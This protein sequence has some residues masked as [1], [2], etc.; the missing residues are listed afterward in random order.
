MH[1]CAK[2]LDQS[3]HY[4]WRYCISKNWGIQKRRHERSICVNLVIDNLFYVVSDTT[5]LYKL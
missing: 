5:P 4:S 3:D 2:F 1:L